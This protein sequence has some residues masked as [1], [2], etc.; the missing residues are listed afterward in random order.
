MNGELHKPVPQLD[1]EREARRAAANIAAQ[2]VAMSI[3][4][5]ALPD[6]GKAA[7]AESQ[8]YLDGLARHKA[9]VEIL[10][11]GYRRNRS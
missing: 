4:L 11:H 1:F 10:R 2:T 8:E 7:L 5:R 3:E 6:G 9:A